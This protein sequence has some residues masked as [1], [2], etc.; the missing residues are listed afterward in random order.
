MARSHCPFQYEVEE[1]PG[2]MTAL[3]GLPLFIEFA[4]RMGLPRLI[5]HHVRVRLG[6]QGWTDEQMIM[7]VM[8]LNVTG[9]RLCR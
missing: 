4:R 1:K 6:N 2:G 8:V 7:A 3:G 9:G 5:A